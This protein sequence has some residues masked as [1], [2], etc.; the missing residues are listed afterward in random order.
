[1]KFSIVIPS[2]NNSAYISET[3]DSILFQRG[4]FEIELI[5]IDNC[6]GDNTIP[7]LKEYHARISR[8]AYR[9]YCNKINLKWVSEPDK[10]MYDAINKGFAL[11]DGNIYAWLNADDIY[12]PGAFSAISQT[13]GKYPEISWLKGI[14]SYINEKSTLFKV[15]HCYLY[16]QEWI[17][18]GLYGPSA[19]FIQQ[20]SCFWRARLWEKTG[21]INPSLK[22]AGDYYLWSL[23]AKHTPLYSL[24]AYISCFRKRHGQL[25][26]NIR[27]YLEECEKI[28]SIPARLKTIVK[29]YFRYESLIPIQIRPYAY[30]LFFNKQVLR[31]IDIS[32]DTIMPIKRSSYYIG[33]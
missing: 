9:S 33:K 22:L 14:T 25:T 23:F 13:F 19:F 1:M 27:G 6:S 7:I 31:F 3:L 11:A 12:L 2:C 17:Q 21:G 32:D 26:T 30:R 4:N 5:V 16:C 20:D 10:G 15:G 29:I 28:I 18:K 8:G 24:A